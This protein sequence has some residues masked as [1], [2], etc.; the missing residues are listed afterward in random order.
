M[1]ARWHI[2][3]IYYYAGIDTVQ[4]C[5]R[6]VFCGKVVSM[7]SAKEA[8]AL[9]DESGAEVVTYLKT[10]I[11]PVVKKAAKAGNRKCFIHI[12]SKVTYQPIPTPTPVEAG[13]IR[14]LK[15]LGYTVATGLVGSPY[16]PGGLQDDDGN[17]PEHQN[18][19]IFIGW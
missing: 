19:G 1:D 6:N 9:Y 15:T 12:G 14:D 7:I 5:Y 18:Y 17:G 4:Y 8:K 13:A 10:V 11:E 16:V 2:F 3:W